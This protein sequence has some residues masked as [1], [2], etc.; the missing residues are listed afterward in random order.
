LKLVLMSSSLSLG[1][2]GNN[3]LFIVVIL[4]AAALSVVSSGCAIRGDLGS[5]QKAKGTVAGALT[6]AGAGAVTGFQVGA[7][8]GP[9][10]L[11]GAGLGMVAGGI[12]GAVVDAE[13]VRLAALRH[14]AGE[15]QRR[16]TGQELL[17]QHFKQRHKLHPARDLYPAEVF[18]RGFSTE[19]CDSGRFVIEELARLS[20]DHLAWSRLSII[21]YVV[22]A[23]E[24]STYANHLAAE[25]AKAIGNEFVKE[26]I[27]PR[28][29]YAQALVVPAPLVQTEDSSQGDYNQV[30]E[31]SLVDA[32]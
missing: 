2:M 14:Q 23:D 4:F 32:E 27:D 10:A 5:D 16:A 20:Q 31:F 17:R 11:V 26:G 22:S 28:R 21:S 15:L 1:K 7:G 9:G 8:T 6:G 30:I 29:I 12:K 25:R 13:E 18:F 3:K 19:L 24:K